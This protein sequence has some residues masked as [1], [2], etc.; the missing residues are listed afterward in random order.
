PADVLYRVP[1]GLALDAAV[2]VL[3]DGRTAGLLIEAASIQPGDR[4][5]IEAAAGGVG[6]LLIQLAKAAGATVVALAGGP[7][8]TGVATGLGADLALDYLDPDWPAG[9]DGPVQ[10]VFDGVGGPIGR[11]AFEHLAAG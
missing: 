5:L 6:S 1:D 9:L 3:A 8:K 2:A 4:V 7:R 11:T 10:V